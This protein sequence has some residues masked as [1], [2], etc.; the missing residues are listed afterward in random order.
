MPAK[1]KMNL[2][3]SRLVK[4]VKK[5]FSLELKRSIEA[6]I[7]EQILLGKSPVKGAKWKQYSKKYGDRKGGRRPVDMLQT[8]KMLESLGVRQR[9]NGSLRIYFGD[10]KAGYHQ[11]GEGNLPQRKLLPERREVFVPSIMRK[12]ISTLKKAVRKSIRQR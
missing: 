1:V 5:N 12:I 7:I 10:K 9:K 8:G 6:D 3:I 11:R 2:G 4:N